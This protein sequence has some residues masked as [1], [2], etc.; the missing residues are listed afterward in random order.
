MPHS[1]SDDLFL[2]AFY[3][4]YQVQVS[5]EAQKINQFLNLDVPHIYRRY[6]MSDSRQ[7]LDDGYSWNVHDQQ[8]YV[9]INIVYS[10]CCQSC[11]TCPT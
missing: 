10:W 6:P 11:P 7:K 8:Y 1:V 3:A 5:H 4:V 9:D 2:S